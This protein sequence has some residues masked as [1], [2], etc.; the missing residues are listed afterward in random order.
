MIYDEIFKCS[1]CGHDEFT[2][3]G[4]NYLNKDSTLKHIRLV[5]IKCKAQFTHITQHEIRLVDS[6]IDL[7]QFNKMNFYHQVYNTFYY[8]KGEVYAT[9]I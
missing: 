8:F 4:I 9:K 6:Y 1:V 7:V 2:L 3:I 5:C